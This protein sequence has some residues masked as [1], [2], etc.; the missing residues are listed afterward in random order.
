ML[1]SSEEK[2]S[3]DG[4]SHELHEVALKNKNLYTKCRTETYSHI[5][6]LFMMDTPEL[7][8]ELVYLFVFSDL[9]P[10]D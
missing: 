4:T 8:I 6:I 5:V 10:R 1:V 7:I 3:T 9:E 2:A